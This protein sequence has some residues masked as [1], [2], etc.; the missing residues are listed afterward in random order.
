MEEVVNVEAY[1]GIKTKALTF[2]SVSEKKLSFFYLRNLIFMQKEVKLVQT[3][4][5]CDWRREDC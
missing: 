5:G 3:F 1:T 2:V 4:C